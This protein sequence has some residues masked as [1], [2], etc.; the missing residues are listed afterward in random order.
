MRSAAL[1]SAAQQ[2]EMLDEM[3]DFYSS[4]VVDRVQAQKIEATH[5]YANRPHTIPL[6]ATLM[7]DLGKQLSEKS[8]SGMQVRMYSDYP[9]RS[10]HDGG[11]K[12]DFERTPWTACGKIPNE[13]VYRFEDFQGRPSLR[14]ATARP[15]QETCVRCH[16]GHAE[17]T[18]KDWK[19][20]EL[21]GVLEIIRPL[22]RDV[23]RT[24]AGLRGTFILMAAIS[25]TLLALTVFVLVA[26]KRRWG[27][28]TT[29]AEPRP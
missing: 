9:F 22:D 6:P 27:P 12:D 18:K 1:E 11:A 16:N 5:D 14:Y 10:R 29:I 28:A 24:H 8:S 3:N 7:I 19:V 4:K 23:A 21:G 17:S 15:M 26:G 25:C 2:S 13:P 20:G